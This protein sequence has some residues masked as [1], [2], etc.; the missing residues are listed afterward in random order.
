MYG[1][2]IWRPFASRVCVRLGYGCGVYI[3]KCVESTKM[4]EGEN[5]RVLESC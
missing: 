3:Y 2:V 5:E 1:M 4:T